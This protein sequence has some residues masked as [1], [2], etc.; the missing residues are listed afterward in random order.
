MSTRTPRAQWVPFPWMSAHISAKFIIW[1]S[2]AH[3]HLAKMALLLSHGN[4]SKAHAFSHMKQPSPRQVTELSLVSLMLL[5]GDLS[6]LQMNPR[7]PW[8]APRVRQSWPSHMKLRVSEG[9]HWSRSPSP[10]AVLICTGE[11]THS[12]SS[13]DLGHYDLGHQLEVLFDKPSVL[14]AGL[15]RELIWRHLLLMHVQGSPWSPECEG[16]AGPGECQV[17]LLP[18]DFLAGVAA[19]LGHGTACVLGLRCLCCGV[20][21][22]LGHRGFLGLFPKAECQCR[23]RNPNGD[24]RGRKWPHSGT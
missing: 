4:I 5:C 19:C 22:S 24:P 20:W 17:E 23:V 13:L 18:G 12:A 1:L 10:Q 9:V 16:Q 11:A 6:R 8:A 21:W 14:S 3:G 15:V 2:A 7:P